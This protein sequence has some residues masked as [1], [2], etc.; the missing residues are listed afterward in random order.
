MN[1]N[2]TRLGFVAVLAI[3]IGAAFFRVSTAEERVN[4]RRAVARAVCT[5]TGGVWETVNGREVCDKG[6]FAKKE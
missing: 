3:A 6:E 1:I 4:E 5:S 2:V